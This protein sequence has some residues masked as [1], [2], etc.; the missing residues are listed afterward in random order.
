MNVN[1]T[2]LDE[3]VDSAASVEKGVVVDKLFMGKEVEITVNVNG[4]EVVGTR[5]VEEAPIKKGEEVNVFIHRAFTYGADGKV[6]N[7]KVRVL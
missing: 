5:N 2:R 3:K 4:I 7:G 1:I 6:E